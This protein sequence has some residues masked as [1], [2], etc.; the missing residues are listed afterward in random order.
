[1]AE[2]E[3]R[4]QNSI[5]IS[6]YL[7]E[8][9][10]ESVSTEKSGQVIRGS[11]IIATDNA[12]SYKVQFYTPALTKS[13]EDSAEYESLS[14]LLDDDIISVASYIKNNPSAT[15]EEAS[16]HATKVWVQ[17]RFEEFA[18]KVG[19]RSRS[20]ILLKGFKAGEKIETEASPFSPRAEFTVDLFIEDI[21]PET[22]TEGET[23]KE[24]GRYIING[25]LP[26]WDESVQCIDFIAPTE[27]GI[28]GYMAANFSK[29]DTLTIK[30]ELVSMVQRVLKEG[31][32]NQDEFFGEAPQP[33]YETLFTRE[34]IITGL[35][36]KPIKQ[37]EQGCISIKSVQEGMAKRETKMIENGKRMKSNDNNESS[38]PKKKAP[39]APTS[40]KEFA[41]DLDF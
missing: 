33:Q 40:S 27:K 10:L 32:E 11:V 5:H 8:N 26:M 14:R 29:N 37:G 7:K 41:A 17:A 31:T 35:T 24:T 2:K 38:T 6:G 28:A 21:K 18:S 34:R 3:K 25:V 16:K 9:N 12:N 1:M 36:K 20:M 13:G 15:F 4:F 39:A 30:G 19:E 23:E 22:V